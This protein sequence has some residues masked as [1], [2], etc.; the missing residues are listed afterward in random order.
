VRA[1]YDSFPA[2]V[3]F[4]NN[5]TSDPWS[6][7]GGRIEHASTL[8]ES[9]GGSWNQAAR[10]TFREMSLDGMTTSANRPVIKTTGGNSMYDYEID[11]CTF[12]AFRGVP[13]RVPWAVSL[14]GNEDTINLRRCAIGNFAGV[15]ASAADPSLSRQVRYDRCRVDDRR[16]DG[17]HASKPALVSN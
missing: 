5:G 3:V 16:D 10:V 13:G 14:G 4:K 9:S 7:E 8:L 6:F 15:A 1:N 12:G 17:S 2:S 11:R